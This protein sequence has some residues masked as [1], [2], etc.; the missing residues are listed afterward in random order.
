MD[1]IGFCAGAVVMVV[2]GKIVG[3]VLGFV[4]AVWAAWPFFHLQ[5]VSRLNFL[6]PPSKAYEGSCPEVFEQL[7]QMLREK[8]Y[9]FGDRWRIITADTQ[10]NK[11]IADLQ[12]TDD[13]FDINL[14]KRL[15]DNKVRRFVRLQ[16]LF[17]DRPD[18]KTEVKMEFDP[19][20]EGD[21][22]STCDEVIKAVTK[23]FEERVGHGEVVSQGQSKEL[24]PPPKWLIGVTAIALLSAVFLHI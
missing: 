20:A 2:V 18:G 9:R 17:V 11:L 1:A 22:E 14:Q 5:N 4:A 3:P 19:K 24:P 16:T 15:D 6:K 7:H 21:D 13:E 10:N 12:Y 23:E 8:V